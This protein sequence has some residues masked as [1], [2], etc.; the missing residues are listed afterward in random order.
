MMFFDD[1]FCIVGPLS[2]SEAPSLARV[3]WTAW[4][5]NFATVFTKQRGWILFLK[6]VARST[7]STD[8]T[9]GPT[10]SKL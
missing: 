6:N 4:K 7:E 3:E 5:S 2:S 10:Q 8:S 1:A 9:F